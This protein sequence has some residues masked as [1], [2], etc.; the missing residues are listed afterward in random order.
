M[1]ITLI[2]DG[3][4]IGLALP[5]IDQQTV[6]KFPASFGLTNVVDAACRSD[7]PLP[8]CTTATLVT[9]ATAAAWLW[10]DSLRPGPLLH[11]RMAT[12]AE[13][14]ARTNPF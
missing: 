9:G 10:A 6:V 8:G 12:A 2:N 11:S 3:R 14:R 13:T 1:S 7:A 4:L 5:D